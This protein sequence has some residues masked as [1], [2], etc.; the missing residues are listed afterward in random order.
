[1]DPYLFEKQCIFNNI[2]LHNFT[3]KYFNNFPVE[4]IHIINILYVDVCDDPN[5]ITCTEN[6]NIIRIKKNIHT[7]KNRIE[8][9]KELAHN[10][11]SNTNSF[12]IKDIKSF[13]SGKEY[14][15]LLTLDGLYGYGNNGDGQL[16][17][18]N[19]DTRH[20]PRKVIFDKKI[21]S[22][23]CGAYHT[24]VITETRQLY[25]CG[26][27]DSGQLGLPICEYTYNVL[28]YCGLDSVIAVSCGK[29]HT[30]VLTKNGLY[31][32][33]SN[34]SLE[35]GIG[36]SIN[37]YKPTKININNVISVHCGNEFTIVH[38][39]NGT[40]TFGLNIY[41][42]GEL[43]NTKPKLIK[44]QNITSIKCGYDYAI[45][46]TKTTLYKLRAA[47]SGRYTNRPHQIINIRDV[48]SVG[49]GHNNC[50]LMTKKNIYYLDDKINDSTINPFNL[51]QINL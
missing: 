2:I 44:I 41:G 14:S 12:D 10:I 16:G 27:N 24:L 34:G 50:I 19:Y 18:G 6:Y 51:H 37:A 28:T 21:V 47:N 39:K 35:L 33:G 22:V 15:M 5:L 11:K 48:I 36:N 9:L 26:C 23:T 29:E 46:Q 43:Y 42:E 8:G 45:I 31:G 49:I 4:L 3:N 30:M 1:M 32:F 17:V 7:F 38:T 13:S 25:G 20:V 40:Y